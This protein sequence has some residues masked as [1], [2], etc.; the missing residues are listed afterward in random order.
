[1]R[2]GFDVSQTGRLKAGC[3]YFADSLIRG[4]SEIDTKNEYLLY[5]TFGDFY[6]DPEWN[7]TTVKVDGIRIRRGLAHETQDAAR[8]F[9]SRPPV[10]VEAQLGHPD[11]VHANNFF[12]PTTLRKAALVYTLYDL[13]FLEHPE[14]TTEANRSGCFDGVFNASLYADRII[15]ISQF[16]RRHFLETFPHYPSERVVVVPPA[17]RFTHRAVIANPEGLPPL[18]PEQFWLS[19]G[20][21]E[22]RKNQRRLLRAY[23]ELQVRWGRTF[24]LVLVGGQGWMM[25]DFEELVTE[26]GL[27][28]DV[29]L[30]GYVSD[31]TLQWLYQNC[32]AFVYPSLFEGFGLPAL[33][34]MSCG[35]AVIT[36][37]TTSLPEIVGS[38]GVL[39]DPWREE[40]ITGAM[41]QLSVG[42]ID[43]EMLKRQGLEQAGRFSWRQAAEQTRD[44]Y[45]EVMSERKAPRD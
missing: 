14:W 35:A 15:A 18:A 4:L 45:H 25:N 29:I 39:V 43:R 40:A 10:D 30:T 17:S 36:S 11:V 28:S 5:P 3:G 26:L 31:D 9:W 42:E 8:A 24:P 16:S 1:M 6:F 32:F 44:V 12:C 38:T 19:V 41:R 2:I 37:T 20:T 34:A 7:T 21:L 27:G 13:S 33:E 22:P 23:A